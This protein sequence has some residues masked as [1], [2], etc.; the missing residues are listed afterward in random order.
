MKKISSQ[1]K[2]TEKMIQNCIKLKKLYASAFSHYKLRQHI[3]D[4]ESHL[5]RLKEQRGKM[6]QRNLRKN[7]SKQNLSE[8]IGLM[9]KM[10]RQRKE[11]LRSLLRENKERIVMD[12]GKKH[13]EV[14]IITKID[15]KGGF[16][17]VERG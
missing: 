16:F 1:I 10:D 17:S 6:V 15:L 3:F 7:F 5:K 8:F 11:N 14:M 2:Q 13:G 9:E 12:V 4:L